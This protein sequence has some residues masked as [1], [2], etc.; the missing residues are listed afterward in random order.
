MKLNTIEINVDIYDYLN[1]KGMQNIRTVGNNIM[2]CCPFHNEHSPSFGVH[3]ENGMY[4]CFGC[5]IRGNF[6]TLVKHLDGFDT[7]HDAFEYLVDVYGTYSHTLDEPLHLHFEESERKEMY[8]VSDFVLDKYKYRHPYLTKRGISEPWQRFFEI[9]YSTEKKAITIPYRDEHSNLVSIKFRKVH[10]KSFWYEPS[11][12]PN[13]KKQTLYSFDKALKSSKKILAITEAEIDCMS[14][15]Q[16]NL[17]SAVAIGGNQFSEE[18][19]T[20]MIRYLPSDTEILLFVDND[21]G[22]DVARKTISTKLSGYFPI[23]TVDWSSIPRTIKDANDLT[24]TEITSLIEN[25]KDFGL[26]LL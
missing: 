17:A 8:S 7:V 16:S 13:V 9:G 19:A 25:R 20:K 26:K 5:G 24:V 10:Q 23:S 2:A 1:E 12:P 11:M 4:Q 15:W 18:Q 6:Q 3:K 22:G 21:A 14:V